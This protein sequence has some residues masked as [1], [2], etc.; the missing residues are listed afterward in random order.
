M[1]TVCVDTNIWFYALARPAEGEADKHKAARQLISGL[2]RPVL[3]PQI[4]NELTFNL[5]RKKGW[6]ET[7][8][9][10][11]MDDMRGRCRFLVPNENWH[12]AAS[13][14][15]EQYKL[16]FWDSLVVASAVASGCESLFSEDMQPGLRMG[17]LRIINPF[18]S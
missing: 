15:R 9:R 8:L 14:L 17:G 6:S 10:V 2:D 5:L 7:E 12:E 18:A 11:L 16:S 13:H 1:P 3:T 4:L